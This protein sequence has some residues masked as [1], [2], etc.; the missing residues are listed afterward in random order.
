MKII[1]ICGIFTIVLVIIL[2]VY[3]WY[4]RYKKM[5]RLEYELA[6][7][8]DDEF[9]EETNEKRKIK[10]NEKTNKIYIILSSLLDLFWNRILTVNRLH[11][12]LLT[13]FVYR[14]AKI[15]KRLTTVSKIHLNGT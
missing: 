1:V 7:L 8:D 15:L 5:K 14:K 13:L 2:F 12:F 11:W 9:H 10:T 6:I 3:R 4:E